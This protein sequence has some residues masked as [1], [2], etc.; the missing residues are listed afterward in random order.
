[1]TARRAASATAAATSSQP[2]VGF[3]S[4][5]SRHLLQSQYSKPPRLLSRVDINVYHLAENPPHLPTHHFP[6]QASVRPPSRPSPWGKLDRQSSTSP[7]HLATEIEPRSSLSRGSHWFDSTVTYYRLDTL[8][9]CTNTRT[10]IRSP[11]H[12]YADVLHIPRPTHPHPLNHHLE[13]APPTEPNRELTPPIPLPTL[14]PLQLH[15]LPPQPR[16]RLRPLI[17]PQRRSSLHDADLQI[18]RR[19]VGIRQ[20]G[21]DLWARNLL[22]SAEEGIRWS[23]GSCHFGAFRGA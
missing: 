21:V 23:W 4:I 2:T 7:L 14:L 13:L 3:A 15:H 22:V 10:R 18:T 8:Y 6:N 19:G 5:C 20:R 12:A 16:D 17:V 1:M 9:V 11:H